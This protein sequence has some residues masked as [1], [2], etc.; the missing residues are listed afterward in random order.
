[1]DRGA[2]LA[3]VHGITKSQT[4]TEWLHFHF[5][6]SCIGKWNGAPLQCSCLE[7]PRD[8]GAWWA[9]IYG[10]AQSQTRLKRLSSSSRDDILLNVLGGTFLDSPCSP[11]HFPRLDEMLFLWALRLSYVYLSHR[12]G[13][14]LIQYL[15]MA[16]WK[17]DCTLELWIIRT[18]HGPW[19]VIGAPYMFIEYSDVETLDFKSRNFVLILI[20]PP[21]CPPISYAVLIIKWEK[22]DY[23]VEVLNKGPWKRKWQPTPVFLPGESQGW[24][25]LV[26]CHLWGRTESHMTEAT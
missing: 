11:L 10:V 20:L 8:G 12:N 9:A 23:K 16:F 3:A 18:L 25:S 5:S 7:N 6:L 4:L 26:G 14:F 21:D 24:G 19:H 13:P 1:M 2:W 17:A 15:P 22:W